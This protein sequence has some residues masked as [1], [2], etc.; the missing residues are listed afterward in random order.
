M[1][2]LFDECLDSLLNRV[3]ILND[4]ESDILVEEFESSF[5][6]TTYGRVDWQNVI[7]KHFLSDISD[8]L[9]L[10]KVANDDEIFIIWDDASYPVVRAKLM[11]VLNSIEDVIAVSFDTWLYCADKKYVVEFYHE[12]QTT[13]GVSDIEDLLK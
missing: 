2:S 7:Q 6:I 12:G 5:E 1:K 3:N 9:N 8:V 4:D 11:D 10:D 13:F